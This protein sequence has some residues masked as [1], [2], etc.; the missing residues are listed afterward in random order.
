[1][2]E[3]QLRSN[4]LIKL[5]GAEEIMQLTT[6]H[7]S[8]C[9]NTIQKTLNE[10]LFA[11][12]KVKYRVE[13]RQFPSSAQL[14]AG[15]TALDTV[16]YYNGYKKGSS[17]LAI[18]TTV[19]SV[20]GMSNTSNNTTISDNWKF[21]EKQR[22]TNESERTTWD[23]SI[24]NIAS[25]ILQEYK[26][27]G[28]E[29][30]ILQG[31]QK[32]PG[33]LTTTEEFV[34]FYYQSIRLRFGSTATF[35]GRRRKFSGVAVELTSSLKI[36][37]KS[38][39][40]CLVTKKGGES[41]ENDP[42]S[43]M[44]VSVFVNDGIR[45]DPENTG[46]PEIR[47]EKSICGTWYFLGEEGGKGLQLRARSVGGYED[48]LAA[49]E[50][51]RRLQNLF[52]R[53]EQAY[54]EQM[55][56]SGAAERTTRE[57]VR[58][59]YGGSS[60]PRGGLFLEKSGNAV[61]SGFG[62]HIGDTYVCTAVRAPVM[63]ADRT[64]YD[65]QTTLG[66]VLGNTQAGDPVIK[67]VAFY[68]ESRYIPTADDAVKA[69]IRNAPYL[70]EKLAQIVT[71][72]NKSVPQ[73][74]QEARAAVTNALSTNAITTE[75]AQATNNHI[76]NSVETLRIDYEGVTIPQQMG[77]VLVGTNPAMV[78]GQ[79]IFGPGASNNNQPIPASQSGA[80]AV[81][82]VV[83]I[84][85]NAA[86]NN[87][88]VTHN[89]TNNPHIGTTLSNSSTVV[90]EGSAPLAVQQDPP[91]NQVPSNSLSA[92]VTNAYFGTGMVGGGGGT[93]V[94]AENKNFNGTNGVPPVIL[95]TVPEGAKPEAQ[96]LKNVSE[97][98]NASAVISGLPK[99][100]TGEKALDNPA[101]NN[102]LGQ[103]TPNANVG[104]VFQTNVVTPPAAG[105]TTTGGNIIADRAPMPTKSELGEGREINQN[106]NPAFGLAGLGG[107]DPPAN[108][109]IT[110]GSSG[111]IE[112]IFSPQIDPNNLGTIV[113]PG[114]QTHIPE[115]TL[116]LIF[117]EEGG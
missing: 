4:G 29:Q 8:I 42:N 74:E 34:K 68:V 51:Q 108:E 14:P 39:Y 6:N 71:N 12:V 31:L 90:P 58:N 56:A 111:K 23:G 60:G 88:T 57:I 2:A 61:I 35:S 30:K 91:T 81:G 36:S 22:T 101:T 46:I 44:G 13:I 105:V 11:E 98:T 47:L 37:A 33:V 1:M 77:S 59:L 95:G 112:F 107:G 100:D 3:A 43:Q 75:Q 48:F 55:A 117:S 53:R 62:D 49:Q 99:A 50:E 96:T 65:I 109:S 54:N 41:S 79:T 9:G 32:N 5:R 40:S 69:A 83:G 45:N 73:K 116:I 67:G 64:R 93:T 18:K 89:P 80:P 104:Y 82:G 24:T 10:V 70:V 28:L 103:L 115:G 78:P 52:W 76:T 7:H 20:F 106:F 94:T 63:S 113:V 21:S 17:N 102:M 15:W 87:Q 27:T 16:S 84:A 66:I 25:A 92:V 110:G 26:S 19:K 38:E 85:Q 97:G 114:Q 72:K 86:V